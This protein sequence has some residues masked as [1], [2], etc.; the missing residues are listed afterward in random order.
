MKAVA[1]IWLWVIG[2]I[3]LMSVMGLAAKFLLFPLFIANQVSDTAHGVVKKTINADNV[4]RNYEQFKDLYNG[5]EQ[6]VM[7]I[8]NAQGDID[9]FKQT[10]GTDV[11]K[12][13][14][15]A[16]KQLEFL[17]QTLQGYKQ[18][19][20]RTV[21]DYNSNASKLNR[22]LFKD[23]NLPSSLPLDSTQWGN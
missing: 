17:N 7:N 21:A 9:N 23:R 13:N 19:Y 12:Y 18:Q 2:I 16:Q 11:T 1:K 4:L 5:A 20:Q 14:D 6:Q 22:N 8:K 10:Y 15:E 3:A